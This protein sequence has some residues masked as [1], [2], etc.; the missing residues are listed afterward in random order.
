MLVML[1]SGKVKLSIRSRTGWLPSVRIGRDLFKLGLPAAFE[2]VVMQFGFISLVAI[3][4]SIGTD[5]LA[6]QQIS[7]T[8]M[9]IAFLPTIAFAT[10]STAFVGQS[11]GARRMDEGVMAA[12]ISRKWALIVT[13]SGLMFM[14]IFAEQIVRA[15]SDDPDV[16]EI[17][18]VAMRAIGCSLP[19]WGLWM[20]SAGAAR[21]SGDTRSPM[22]RGVT[23]VWLAVLLAWIGV[24]FLDQSIA[25]I[26]GTFIVTGLFP[27][28]G[29]WRAFRK[30]AAELATAF[31][32]DTTAPVESAT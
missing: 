4:A 29:N 1:W 25:W 22:I 24:H 2:Q 19:I 5:A 28:L 18:T 6:A 21:G 17:G 11:V 12:K 16:I 8:A 27:A 14:V 23:A 20:S 30:R 13:V 31:R 10:T 26:W 9:S 3:A 7:F 15:F 32:L